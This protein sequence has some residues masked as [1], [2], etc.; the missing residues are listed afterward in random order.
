MKPTLWDIISSDNFSK[1]Y[2]WTYNL[3]KKDFNK[4]GI[5]SE[6][7]NYGPK[8]ELGV[9]YSFMIK[10]HYLSALDGYLKKEENSSVGD[11][12]LNVPVNIK[13]LELLNLEVQTSGIFSG[14]KK[15]NKTKKELTNSDILRGEIHYYSEKG[16]HIRKQL[17][18]YRSYLY[19]GLFFPLDKNSNLDLISKGVA[20]YREILEKSLSKLHRD[21][22]ESMLLDPDKSKKFEEIEQNLHSSYKKDYISHHRITSSDSGSN[23][24]F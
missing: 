20:F 22:Q 5:N 12:L 7:G 1:N 21:Y 9:K 19:T 14:F 3:L 11:K 10:R 2:S 16:T 4:Y 23:L 8:G 15:E 18:Y 17:R 24:P 13:P 6:L